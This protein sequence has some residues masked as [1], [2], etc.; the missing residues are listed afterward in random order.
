MRR[1]SVPTITRWTYGAKPA[2]K[3]GKKRRRSRL[4]DVLPCLL[5]KAPGDHLDPDVSSRERFVNYLVQMAGKE[6]KN[7]RRPVLGMH[8]MSRV[9]LNCRH[10]ASSLEGGPD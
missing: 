2:V 3:R 8:T 1:C 9:V 5:D 10:R 4:L 7:D 6:P